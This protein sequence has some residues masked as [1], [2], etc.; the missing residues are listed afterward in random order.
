VDAAV[1]H[2]RFHMY[3]QQ[4]TRNARGFGTPV[5]Y[6]HSLDG[7]IRPPVRPVTAD[8]TV[9]DRG[10]PQMVQSNVPGDPHANGSPSSKV[11]P[12][13]ATQ[14]FAIPQRTERAP[15]S[16]LAVRVTNAIISKLWEAVRAECELR[17]YDPHEVS[18]EVKPIMRADSVD[19][20]RMAIR[21]KL[22][23]GF[24]ERFFSVYVRMD[25]VLDAEK[26]PV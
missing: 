26:V 11:E 20:I 7:V 9:R 22:S 17:S 6:L 10:V 21:E 24:T 18:T 2:A 3:S 12:A 25:G 1:Q 8:A 16:Q 4:V 23:G 13:P 19:N 14:S 15:E 5:L